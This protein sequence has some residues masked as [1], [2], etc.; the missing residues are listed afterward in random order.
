MTCEPKQCPIH[1]GVRIFGD[2]WS[3]IIVRDMLFRGST[4]FQDFLDAAEGISTNVLS[5]RL[6][7]LEAQQIISRQRDP[8]NGRQ[9]LYELTEKGRDLL[10]VLLAVIGWADKY[11]P[12]TSISKEM[13]ERIRTD[14]S[15]VQD[16]LRAAVERSDPGAV[17]S[18]L[19]GGSGGA[20]VNS[21]GGRGRS[22]GTG[23]LT[24]SRKK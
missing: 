4:R 18:L 24:Q 17:M 22:G 10:P 11:A 8:A 2:R 14:P 21:P 6:S 23:F 19:F 1:F 5:D 7:R 9:V 12:E 20:Q 3:L 13:G 15:G 16:E